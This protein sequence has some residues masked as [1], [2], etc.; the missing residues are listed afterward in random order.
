MQIANCRNVAAQPGQ[1]N[2]FTIQ[3]LC[4]TADDAWYGYVDIS[5][6]TR[7]IFS[8][9][10]AHILALQVQYYLTTLKTQ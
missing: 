3:R 2:N 10:E 9:W 5:I 8:H 6:Q 1:S 4:K 7:P